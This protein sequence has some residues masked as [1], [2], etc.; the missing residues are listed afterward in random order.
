MGDLNGDFLDD[1]MYTE[2]GSSSQILVALQLPASQ[3][4]DPPLFYT[5]SFDHALVI[6][7]NPNAAENSPESA[8][9]QKPIENKR[10][11]V[12]HSTALID[13]DGDC[14]ADLFVTIQDLTT[15][16]KYY[17]I[18][19]RREKTESVEIAHKTSSIVSQT[20]SQTGNGKTVVTSESSEF[21]ESPG[22][23]DGLGS[24]CLV[25]REEV[26]E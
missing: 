6:R 15:G 19:L 17:E 9:I 20:T 5:T 13:F 12:P 10:L 26:P 4:S 1:I 25:S 23:L 8:C 3:P 14:M 18:Y 16:K 2:A 21:H 24:F 11:T 22:T 7:S